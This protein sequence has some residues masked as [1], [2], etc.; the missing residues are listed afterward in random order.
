[1][2]KQETLDT[3]STGRALGTSLSFNKRI[4]RSAMDSVRRGA[5]VRLGGEA[6][7]GAMGKARFGGTWVRTTRLVPVG[8][9]EFKRSGEATGRLGQRV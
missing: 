5:H 4:V 8:E 6:A 1:M 7:D 3:G 9:G 2:G